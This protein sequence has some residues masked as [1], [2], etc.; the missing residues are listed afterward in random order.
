MENPDFLTP[1]EYEILLARTDNPR[2]KLQIL[3]MGE[4]GLRVSEMLNL[5]WSDCDFKKKL[6]RVRSLKKREADTFRT[7]PI[8]DRLYQAFA[9]VVEKVK[10]DELKGYIFAGADGQPI[11]R[12]AVNMMLKRL[13]ENHPD[14]PEVHP[15]KLRHTFATNLRVNGAELAD[16]R[17]VLGHEKLETSLIYAHADNEKIRQIINQKDEKKAVGL[18]EKAR[19]WLG[20]RPSH[21]PAVINLTALDKSF[22]IGRDDEIKQ[23]E[24]ALAKGLNVV[25]IGSVGIG[26][27]HII[28][29]LKF[30]K[31][32]IELDNVKD[33][34]KSLLNCIL[35]LFDDD[36]ET[37]AAMI[38]GT[39]DKSKWSTKMSTE[40][41][42]NL[43]KII[44]ELTG[45]GEYILKIGDIDELTPTVVKA[46]EQLN[47][48]FQILTTARAVKMEHINF[49]WNFERIDIKP[50]DRVN[51]LRLFH[52]LSDH[53][54]FENL[55][56]ARNQVWNTSEGNPKK[57]L[58]LAER[59]GKEPILTGDVV[60]EIANNYIGKR[61]NEI[62]MSLVLF[63]FLFGVALLKFIGK[64]TDQS[65]LR[66][67]GS[68]IML[69]LMFVRFFFRGSKRK[70]F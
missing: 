37:A 50:L 20:L 44:C 25:L 10:A 6:L 60:E 67:I 7:I 65:D 40:S 32:V 68:A 35:W 41:L 15:H 21:A 19:G 70:T 16:I 64:A 27:T 8:S 61:T 18:W 9:V 1:K 33:F 69:V 42:P 34:K 14:T 47:G 13:Q 29:H 45:K 43:I 57:I 48:H 4:A 46:L 36:K 28:E 53:L 12:T 58:E 56:F 24:T 55:E 26:K 31:K 11:N 66:F 30:N 63:A 2:H 38:T 17:D 39:R 51:S 5:K 49:M 52:K 62:D 23:I 54:Q 3:I 59:F 22:V